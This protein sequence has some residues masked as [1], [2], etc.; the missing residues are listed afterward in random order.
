MA[1]AMEEVVVRLIIDQPGWL[2]Y[3]EP[4]LPDVQSL[5]HTPSCAAQTQYCTVSQ[6]NRG[7]QLTTGLFM[8]PILSCAA[9]KVVGPEDRRFPAYG[10]R[11]RIH[12]DPLP[13]PLGHMELSHVHS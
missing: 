11:L 4:I 3:P 8:D 2:L 5:T 1:M 12:H 6:C 10:A 13:G 7:G 9:T